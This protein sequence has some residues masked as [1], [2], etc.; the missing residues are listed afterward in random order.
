MPALLR[1]APLDAILPPLKALSPTDPVGL[2]LHPGRGVAPRQFRREWG[3][4]SS[5]DNEGAGR[6]SP[7]HGRRDFPVGGGGY[8][9]RGNG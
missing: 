9:G 5:L 2:F 7:L 6:H 4:S 3:L 8:F 1:K